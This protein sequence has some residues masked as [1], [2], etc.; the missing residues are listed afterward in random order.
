MTTTSATR[1]ILASASPYRATMLANAGV[2]VEKMPALIDER[3]VE[4]ALEKSELMPEDVAQ[5]LAQAKADDVSS[6]VIDGYVIG[7]DQTLSLDGMILHKPA[8]M[9]AA[10]A[11]LIALS[12]RTHSLNSAVCIVRNGEVLWTHVETA[13]ITFRK[14]D[15]QFIGRHLGRVGTKAL[16]SVGAYQVEGEG[17]QLIDHMEGDFF[18]IIGL[19]LLPLLRQLRALEIIDG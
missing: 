15:P 3:A 16:T 5:V 7:A 1:L 13:H 11:R 8:D 19:P 17:A 18:S 2:S 9:D 14:L 12:G 4:E 6:R 10:I